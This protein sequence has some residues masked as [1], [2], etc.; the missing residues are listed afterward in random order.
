M[1]A[2]AL[3]LLLV[4][5]FAY[6][7]HEKS[8]KEAADLIAKQQHDAEVKAQQQLADQQAQAAAALKQAQADAAAK[9]A[10]VEAQEKL[11]EAKAADEARKHHDDARGAINIATDPTGATIAIGDMPP[12]ISPALFTDLKLGN[13]P[14][15]ITLPNYEPTILNIEVKENETADPGV[16]K[17]AHQTGSLELTSE[18]AGAS[19]TVR[20]ANNMLLLNTEGLTGTTPATL[21]QLPIG[22]Y[23]VTF[24]REGFQPHSDTVTVSH[25][26]PAQSSWKF[27]NG[28]V[29]VTS[30][31]SGATVTANDGSVLGVTPVTINN[32][33]PGDITYTLTLDGYD[34]ATITGKIEGGKTNTIDAT[35]LSVNRLA[36]LADLDAQPQPIEQPQPVIS[37]R[38]IHDSG[39]VEID[40]TV[41]RSGNTKD[42][43]VVKNTTNNPEIERLCLDAISKWKYKPGLIDDKPVNVR[44]KVPFAITVPDQQ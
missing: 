26:V 24:S 35:L 5:Y 8:V 9:L 1:A 29:L 6:S 10:A 19:Y 13:Y 39:V 25:D 4:V 18:P 28:N 17:L 15:T 30:T 3:V 40:F 27:V 41:D 43:T 21:N 16:V 31:P 44:L 33:L 22:D 34:P 7:S 37:E 23:I 14:V 36:N 38:T 20:S 2:A 32:V 12:R 11:E 42:L